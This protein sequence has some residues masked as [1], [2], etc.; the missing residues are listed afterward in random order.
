MK[1]GKVLH[2]L[3]AG[4]LL[5]VLNVVV[6][7]V[8]VANR[9]IGAST[10]FPYLGGLITHLK[11]AAYMQVIAKPG[12]WELYFLIGAFIGG[13]VSSL[14]FGDF[15]LKLVPSRWSKVK[16]ENKGKRILWAAI[17]GFLLILGARLAG[18]CTS[19]HILSGGMQLS[20]SSLT[21]GVVVIISFL[22][23]GK[24]F[25]GRAK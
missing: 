17:G 5:G 1:K 14:A 6:M 22:I 12:N 11:N 8:H 7:N 24:L 4:I 25:Y 3:W 2:W 18:G 19:G 10:M 13:L 16:G 23:T 9:P 15:K 21:F 20:V